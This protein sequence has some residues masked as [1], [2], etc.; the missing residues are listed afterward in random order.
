MTRRLLL[1][2]V[3]GVVACG[4]ATEVAT[5]KG[6]GAM[7]APGGVTVPG[8]ADRYIAISPRSG[9]RLTVV[10]RVDRVGG[11]LGRW[12]YLRGTWFVPAVAYDFSPGG[13]SADGS[14]LVLQRFNRAYPPPVSR[15]A[16]LDTQRAF[17]WNGPGRPPRTR[18]FFD[19]V[20]LPG[21]FS[22][23]AISPDGSTLYLI[24]RY[25]PLSSAGSYITNYRVRAYDLER[26]RLL[27]QPIV[28]PEEPDERM[29][30]LP[31][32]RAS[33]PDGRWAYTLYDGDGGEPFIHA[34]DT[35]G[36]TAVCIDL[37]QLA[38]R[39]FKGR[40][41]NAFNFNLRLHHDQDGGQLT[42][43]SAPPPPRELPPISQGRPI[44][45]PVPRPL[46]SVDTDTF[47]VTKAG[48]PATGVDESAMPWLPL[49]IAAVVL[50]FGV[51]WQAGRKRKPLE[52]A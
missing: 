10:A 12:W 18:R 29:A 52:R 24:Q 45:Y 32:T 7:P 44:S 17:R 15:F 48:A 47:E 35:V 51:A 13:L 14:T 27:P 20:A 34:L 49:G 37:P 5:A 39:R 43:M 23:D 46:V 21:D 40:R 8:S 26:G 9:D 30:G 42:V 11:K 31:V 41:L 36:R 19:Y 38:G 3:L 1:V 2:A 33:S 4:T 22:F 28:D 25:L 6:V 16:V 50:L